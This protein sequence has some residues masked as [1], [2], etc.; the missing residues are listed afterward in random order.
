MYTHL[1]EVF[2]PAQRGYRH[3]ALKPN[4][5]R[6]TNLVTEN[7]M[8]FAFRHDPDDLFEKLPI[9]CCST[10]YIY[11]RSVFSA[12]MPRPDYDFEGKTL[13]QR[14]MDMNYSH[15]QLRTLQALG[16][17]QTEDGDYY[18]KRLD[19]IRIRYLDSNEVRIQASTQGKLT[20]YVRPPFPGMT[21]RCLD[22]LSPIDFDNIPNFILKGE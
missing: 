17:T 13:W 5:A 9:G 4:V 20:Y 19:S 2:I 11:N 6:L 16:F 12:D 1:L 15:V 8:V 22:D 18:T 10:L 7:S 3:P 21:W 14:A